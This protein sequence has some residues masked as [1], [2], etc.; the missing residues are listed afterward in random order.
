MSKY[1]TINYEFA[2]QAITNTES[3]S[4]F[5]ILGDKTFVGPITSADGKNPAGSLVYNKA[6]V[7]KTSSD[8]IGY[9]SIQ[10]ILYIYEGDTYVGSVSYL[11]CWRNDEVKFTES[12]VSNIIECSG[13]F[14][15]SFGLPVWVQV[16]N[17][18][19]LRVVTFQYK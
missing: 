11:H 2:A 16:D 15:N 17:T 18:T 1:Y 10:H 3:D 7:C 12:F 4:S 14:N 9:V 13:K 5:T 6:N 8:T 19:D